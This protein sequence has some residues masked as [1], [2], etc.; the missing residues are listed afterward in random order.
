LRPE[1]V[2]IAGAQEE[3]QRSASTWPNQPQFGKGAE[4]I[5]QPGH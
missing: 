2:D 5:G 1:R 4:E 3:A